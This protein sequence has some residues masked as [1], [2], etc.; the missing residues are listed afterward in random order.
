MATSFMVMAFAV[1]GTILPRRDNRRIAD[2][3]LGAALAS[4]V[5]LLLLLIRA[6]GVDAAL[7]TVAGILFC[8]VAIFF[9]RGR[10][11]ALAGIVLIAF[12]TIFVDETRGSRIITQERS[13]FGVLRTREFADRA[14]PE[15]P[16]LR[17][18]MHGTTIHGAQLMGA[19][20]ER[21]PLTYYGSRT[22]LGEA[23]VAGLSLGPTS[24][25][26]LI[27]LGTGST[28]CLMRP[29]DQLTI[30]EIDPAVVRLSAE[31]GG[32]FTFVPLCQPNRRI[33]LGDAR[34]QI[35]E[36]PDG[37]FDVIVVDAF[38][39]DAI[40]A[41]L[42]TRE[43]IALYLSKLSDRGIVVLHLS[44]RNLALVS[45]AARV[46]HALNAPYLY[47]I[48]DR[49]EQPMVSLYGGLAASVMIIAKQPQ[50]LSVL[51]LNPDWRVIEAPPGRAWTDDYINLP[52]A[53]WDG[54]R[55]AETCLIYPYLKQCER[56]AAETP[57]AS[58]PAAPP[59]P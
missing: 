46:A 23:I 30:F 33:E 20:F 38:S 17:V 42:L 4:V 10:P 21:Q 9:N 49:Y 41:H 51:P 31:P 32:D 13:F 35:A 15:I 22:A 3:G 36:E 43:A 5:L 14:D 45:E 7:L 27:G 57:E 47:R 18:L 24:R 19:D 50:T 53:L 29:N 26:A 6:A 40:P 16:P 39:S 52:R 1:H 48:S 28:A 37:E 58:T 11:I 8:G 12:V 56:A 54:L 59:S 44:N 2:W 55:G 25:L 34:L